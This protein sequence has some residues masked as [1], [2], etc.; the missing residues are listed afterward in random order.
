MNK[1]VLVPHD[2]YESFK[3]FLAEKK[4]EKIT[5]SKRETVNENKLENQMED[6]P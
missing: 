6:I 4:E 3:K 1:Y 2:Q 5:Q